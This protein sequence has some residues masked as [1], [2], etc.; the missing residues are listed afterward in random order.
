MGELLNRLWH[1][2]YAFGASS[3]SV[4]IVA[5][6]QFEDT[7]LW[8]RGGLPECDPCIEVGFG[9]LAGVAT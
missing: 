9:R 4:L 1:H 6:G 8:D 7:G 5:T 3:L 2:Q